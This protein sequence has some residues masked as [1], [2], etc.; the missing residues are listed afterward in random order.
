MKTAKRFTITSV[1]LFFIFGFSLSAQTDE[2]VRTILERF[3]DDFKSDPSFSEQTFGI[4]V[5]GQM[6][7]VT[8]SQKK[9]TDSRAA[10]LKKEKPSTPSF[11]YVTNLTTLRMIDQ[12]K[13]NAMTAGVKAF[14][15][16]YAPLDIEVMEGF[17]PGEDF[18]GEVLAF[19]F[20][21]WTRGV[22]EI[23]PFG[24]HFTRSTHG[25][26]AAVFYYDKGLR[27]GYGY[28]HPGQHANEHPKSK[29]NPFSSM[30]IVIKGKLV[31]RLDGT[32]HT[33]EQGNAIFIPAGMSHEILNPFDE[34]GEIILLMFGEGA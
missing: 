17:Q 20:H 23:I 22:P 27:T 29:T 3:C 24:P 5:D 26:Q 8:T 21:F 33:I 25:A 30:I 14:S 32:D 18:V 28:I 31:A 4:E 15:T 10:I 2:E 19:T 7:H 9:D 16:D 1:L 13:M 34:A 11:Y 6:W 12:G